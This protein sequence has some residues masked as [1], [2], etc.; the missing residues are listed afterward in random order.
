MGVHKDFLKD[1]IAR[2]NDQNDATRIYSL[3]ITNSVAIFVNNLENP[4]GLKYAP[5]GID[6]STSDIII[7][8]K[9]TPFKA[10]EDGVITTVI[11][12]NTVDMVRY[13]EP[14]DEIDIET[15]YRVSLEKEPVV[16]IKEESET[17]DIPFKKVTKEDDT[18]DVTEITQQGVNGIKTLTYSVTYTD[19]VETARDLISEEVTTEPIDEITTV[20]TKPDPVIEVKTE[21]ETEVVPFEK[22]EEEDDTTDVTEVTQQGVDGVRTY[23]YS[24]TYTDG[25]ET[26]KE[27]VS[28][29]IT[30]EPIPEIT[31]IGT[32]QPDPEPDPEEPEE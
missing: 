17:E 8:E 30:T 4:E 28:N 15:G 12:A 3:N 7:R 24:V 13:Y 32:K 19:G 23:T 1:I 21:T 27:L 16:E 9:S 14:G 25:V 31:T 2:H 11:G 29:E 22:L 5:I 6:E 18:T 20:G 10:K 26:N